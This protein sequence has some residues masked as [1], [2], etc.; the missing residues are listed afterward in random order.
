[1]NFLTSKAANGAIGYDEYSY[2]LGKNYPVAKVENTAGYYTLPT[3]YNVAVALILGGCGGSS[4]G[5]ATACSTTALGRSGVPARTCQS[6]P[7][8][9]CPNA[10][11]FYSPT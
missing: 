8:R 11:S 5:S 2:A 6:R 4:S 7:G 9:H 3:Q 10:A 1:M